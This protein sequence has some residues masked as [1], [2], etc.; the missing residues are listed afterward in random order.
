MEAAETNEP[1][2]TEPQAAGDEESTDAAAA[3]APDAPTTPTTPSGQDEVDAGAAAATSKPADEV[4]EEEEEEEEQSNP[5]AN[6]K[7]APERQPAANKLSS[8]GVSNESE[9]ESEELDD[10]QLIFTTEETCRDV[11]LQEDLVSITDTENWQAHQ[12]R[13]PTP[14]C[15]LYTFYVSY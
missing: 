15:R 10:I 13:T 3:S 12:A 6:N 9:N 5:G 7:A 11:G 14:V 1:E 8:Q 2:P 4:D